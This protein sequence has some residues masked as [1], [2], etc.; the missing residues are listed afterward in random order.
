M[1]SSFSWVL[2]SLFALAHILIAI[3]RKKEPIVRYASIVTL[4]SA[5][6]SSCHWRIIAPL[7]SIIRLEVV[8]FWT[9]RNLSN[10]HGQLMVYEGFGLTK[11]LLGERVLTLMLGWEKQRSCS[12][13]LSRQM[14]IFTW[15]TSMLQEGF[16][17][18]LGA[19]SASSVSFPS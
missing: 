5:L 10:C 9:E 15:H 6:C 16:L 3:P 17:I 11:E 4:F 2:Q 8:D 7:K 12:K 14:G 13:F 18:I 1:T 19:T